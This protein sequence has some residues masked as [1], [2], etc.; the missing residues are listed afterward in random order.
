M[1]TA[2]TIMAKLLLDSSGYNKSLAKAKTDAGGLQKGVGGLNNAVKQIT[3][4][5]L[6][7]AS[8]FALAGK[9]MQFC[10]NEAMEAEK[11]EKRLETALTSTRYAAGM[12][13]DALMNY[14][15]A[16][17]RVTV[18][19]EETIMDAESL[20][21]TF[22]KIGKDVFP[23]AMTAAM[24]MSSA[25]NQDLQ[26]S[27]KQLGKALNDPSG[28]M[29]MKKIGVSFS[30]AQ[31]AM[32]KAMYEAGDIAGYQRI[33]LSELNVEAGGMAKAMGTTYVGQVAILKNNLGELAE[34]VGKW[35][36]P[37]LNL[38]AKALN[39]LLTVQSYYDDMVRN[40]PVWMSKAG[41]EYDDYTNRVLDTAIATGN[42]TKRQKEFYEMYS[43]NTDQM[44]V[45]WITNMNDKLGI[46][47]ET[48]Y[49]ASAMGIDPWVKA[50]EDAHNI[51]P[52]VEADLEDVEGQV[53]PLTE[54]FKELT[55]E[56]IYNNLA[57]YLDTQGQLDLARQLGLVNENTYNT[58]GALDT[59]TDTYDTNGDGA[60]SA[61]EKTLKYYDALNKIIATSGTHYW[62]FIVTTNSIVAPQVQSPTSY[63]YVQPTPTQTHTNTNGHAGGGTPEGFADGGS[64][65]VPSW[66]G[67]EG[68]NMGGVA[69]AS[70]G[71]IIEISKPGQQ[72]QNAFPLSR[73]ELLRILTRNQ[74]DPR[75]L[76]RVQTE[77]SVK[78]GQ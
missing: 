74:V 32:A 19:S 65:T 3:G 24:D 52:E 27:V 68:F 12:S 7:S 62:K 37:N 75:E 49:N 41:I 58:I 71:E 25:F 11:S 56:M 45:A 48:T 66:A 63:T 26:S 57:T 16:M 17:S 29:A 35:L 70:A 28:L 21:L 14:A 72:S 9:A 13:K 47:T 22:T 2:A 60:L 64:F 78:W 73:S 23:E 61:E 53:R 59:L 38:A 50:W 43:Q 51:I 44:S 6:L 15:T 76:T 18:N 8:A 33:I 46:L 54:S 40:A 69:T 31:I 77:A 67:Y 4:S 1:T 39:D 36:I 10:V 30:E 34:T 42:L 5:T 20:M 55:S